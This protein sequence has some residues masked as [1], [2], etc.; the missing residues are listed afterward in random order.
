MDG[1][2]LRRLANRT[3]SNLAGL[4][5]HLPWVAGIFAVALG[6]RIAWIL[7]INPDPLQATAFSGGIYDSQMYYAGALGLAAGKGYVDPWLG[8]P[9]ATFPPGYPLVLAGL[10]KLFGPSLLAA[11]LFNAVLGAITAVLVY[12][13]G[14]KIAG[15]RAGIVAGGLM[16]LFPSQIFFSTTI[17]TEPLFV[18]LCVILALLLLAWVG[19]GRAASWWQMLAIGALLGYMSL[20][21]VEAILLVPAVVALWKL[22]GV[23]WRRLVWQA[24]VLLASIA[25][26]IT[27]WTMRNYDQF[28]EV[29]MVRGS[30]DDVSR[31]VRIGLSPDYDNRYKYEWLAEEPASWDELWTYYREM[32]SELALVFGS[33]LRHLFG[34]DGILDWVQ[35]RYQAPPLSPTEVTLWTSVS[36]AYYFTVGAVALLGAPLWFTRRDRRRLLIVWFVASWTLA[37]LI[38]VPTTRYHFPLI[39]ML[40][41]L[42]ALA[43][44]GG[45]DAIRKPGRPAGWRG[46][47]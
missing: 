21:R 16:A 31:V 44:S 22:S 2:A 23:S 35:G 30:N 17:M 28:G 1:S 20:V 29:I 19:E 15:R 5:E 46:S 18:M 39:P 11:K 47:A 40:C 7:H 12:A 13:L 3:A 34:S 9:T 33:K 26:V 27:P 41:V 42:A 32:P 36:N 37:N 45:W 24:P 6:L 14:A 4:R 25:L 43:L 10:F 38:F 8:E